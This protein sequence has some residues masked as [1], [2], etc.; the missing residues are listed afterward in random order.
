M[1]RPLFV[2]LL[3]CSLSLSVQE[4]KA[5]D[6]AVRSKTEQR[7]VASRAVVGSCMVESF[8]CSPHP[9]MYEVEVCDTI[10]SKQFDDSPF[11]HSYNVAS[12]KASTMNPAQNE[13]LNSVLQPLFNTSIDS[14]KF[15]FCVCSSG[16]VKSFSVKM[17][18]DIYHR[19]ALCDL[20]RVIEVVDSVEVFYP[21]RKFY[22]LT[23]EEYG[24]RVEWPQRRASNTQKNDNIE[25]ANMLSYNDLPV[26]RSYVTKSGR[27][28]KIRRMSDAPN[29]YPKYRIYH[30]ILVERDTIMTRPNRTMM[31]GGYRLDAKEALAFR[32]I[33]ANALIKPHQKGE[34][35]MFGIRLY[36]TG[37][38]ENLTIG[39]DST[40]ISR[41]DIEEFGRLF[42]T[43]DN[44][45]LFGR[46]ECS[47]GCYG[48]PTQKVDT[49]SVG[50]GYSFSVP[51][52]SELYD[53][54]K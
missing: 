22:S 2:L 38:V 34:V 54:Y 41:Y 16:K 11:A 39:M 30:Y 19:V 12:V 48:S 13:T 23:D 44:S 20:A 18:A 1:K 17:Q 33:V 43:L 32:S 4:N 42:D 47:P 24:Y 8:L 49:D 10:A 26:L 7:K 28:V 9:D 25:A 50:Y 53:K 6:I 14:L 29:C 46:Y 3:L 36:N 37:E 40:L 21:W 5:I 35:T 31:F 51:M 52:I 27:S 45:K 15:Y